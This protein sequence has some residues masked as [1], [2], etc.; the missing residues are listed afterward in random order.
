MKVGVALL[1]LEEYIARRKNED[2]IN[3]FDV[4]GR[5][6]GVKASHIYF[7]TNRYLKEWELS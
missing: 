4:E 2:N 1:S 3:E 6:E 7:Y 5:M